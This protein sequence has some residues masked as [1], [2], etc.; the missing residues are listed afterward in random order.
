MS[1]RLTRVNLLSAERARPASGPLADARIVDARIVDDGRRVLLAAGEREVLVHPLWLRERS[2]EP[3]AVDPTNRQRLIEPPDV[4]LGLTVL[5]IAVAGPDVR[6]DFGDGHRMTLPIE[7]LLVDLGLLP[8]PE[9][10][11]AAVAWRGGVDRFPVIEWNRVDRLDD[12]IE[13]LDGYFRHGFM[14][15]RGTPTEPGSLLDIA[16]RFGRVSPTNFGVLFDVRSVP[17]PVDLAYTPVG[18]TAHTDQ[19]YR[20]PSPGIQ[21]LHALVN[22]AAG[23]D[24]TVVDGLAAVQGLA[25]DDPQAFDVLSTTDIDYRYDVGADVVVARAPMIDLDRDGTLRRF[26]FS[27]RVDFAPPIEPDLLDA[28]YRG[29]RWLADHLNDEANRI[30]FRLEAGDV[31]VVDNARVLHG[32]TPFDPSVGNRHLQGCYIDHDGPDTMWRLALRRRAAEAG[33]R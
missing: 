6:V 14:L 2:Q 12:V 10:P 4:P 11:P 3:G 30:D 8:D 33:G 7:R 29:R 27:P 19:P 31:I 16:S 13:L 26:R 32:R 5:A 23:G 24:S 21:F 25:L 1:F 28:Y 17:E 18:L 9:A 22:D 15:L 20:R